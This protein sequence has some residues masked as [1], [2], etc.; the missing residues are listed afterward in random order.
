ML[1]SWSIVTELSSK[2]FDGALSVNDAI[3]IFYR[4]ISGWHFVS[5]IHFCVDNEPSGCIA[6]L[7]ADADIWR[8]SDTESTDEG[9]VA[10]IDVRSA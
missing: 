3:F 10:S 5:P 4:I 7:H 9:K 8:I 2:V 6:A 1:G